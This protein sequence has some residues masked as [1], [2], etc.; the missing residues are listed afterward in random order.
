MDGAVE[1]RGE[2]PHQGRPLGH[3][4]AHLRER[5]PRGP[6]VAVVVAAAFSVAVIGRIVSLGSR[7]VRA[8]GRRE[9]PGATRGGR[10]STRSA[11]S[12]PVAGASSSPLRKWPTATTTPRRDLADGRASAGSTR[13]GSP[14]RR[15][16]PRRAPGPC[17]APTPPCRARSSGTVS[18]AKPTSSSVVPTTTRP[19]ARGTARC[20]VAGSITTASRSPDAN[21]IIWPR[22]GATST[23]T[24]SSASAAPAQAPVAITTT[25]APGRAARRATGAPPRSTTMSPSRA[26]A[27]RGVRTVATSGKRTASARAPPRAV[28]HVS[29]SWVRPRARRQSIQPGS[30]PSS[31][32]P[33]RRSSIRGCRRAELGPELQAARRRDRGPRRAAARGGRGRGCPPPP[34]RR[35]PARRRGRP[36]AR[37]PRRRRARARTR[38]PPRRPPARRPSRGSPPECRGHLGDPLQLDRLPRRTPEP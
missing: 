28:R 2:R 38:R 23:S 19:S 14:P 13:G 6:G 1:P 26:A 7:G 16:R 35:R 31:T 5:R 37:A 17:G 12:S 18:G 10:P 27:T 11:T 20:P 24:P 29:A 22:R 8:R 36:P 4:G 33:V 21:S 3:L 34:T 25:S 9:R 32:S 30:L 15:P